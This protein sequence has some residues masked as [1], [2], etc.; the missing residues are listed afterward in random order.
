MPKTSKA[1]K[2]PATRQQTKKAA[3]AEED[4][5]LYSDDEMAD[6]IRILQLAPAPPTS[7][8]RKEV[9]LQHA[10]RPKAHKRQRSEDDEMDEK[11][12]KIMEG[13]AEIVDA[14]KLF[15]KSVVT[16]LNSMKKQLMDLTEEV[17][18]NSPEATASRFAGLTRRIGILEVASTS[19]QGGGLADTLPTLTSVCPTSSVKDA[20]SYF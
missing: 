2:E 20:S 19:A 10:D 11:L 3:M 6:E 7:P 17:A 12:K 15:S 1:P 18:K 16:E 4:A 5:N 9:T 14:I 13:Q 8:G